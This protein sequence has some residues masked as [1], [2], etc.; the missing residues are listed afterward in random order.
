M[1]TLTSGNENG[2]KATCWAIVTSDGRYA[3][4]V[5]AGNGT[6]S[7]YAVSPEG[8]LTLLNPAAATTGTGST[9]TDPALSADSKF[10]YIRDGGLNEVHGFRVESNGS[11]TPVGTTGGLPANGQGIAAR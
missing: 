11:L 2:Q 9:P 1:R 8:I 7:S 10:L 3:Y 4:S 6:I 5:N